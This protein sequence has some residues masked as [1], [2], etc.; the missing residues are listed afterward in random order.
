MSDT[1]RRVVSGFVQ[2]VSENRGAEI[3]IQTD[4]PFHGLAQNQYVILTFSFVQGYVK[5]S[6]FIYISSE[7]AAVFKEQ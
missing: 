5:N 2:D 6:R 1:L 7:K 3:L 4:P